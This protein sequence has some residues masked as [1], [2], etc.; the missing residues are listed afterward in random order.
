MVNEKSEVPKI[1]LERKREENVS[2]KS[3]K[4]LIKAAVIS[5]ISL[6]RVSLGNLP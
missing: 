6:S 1:Y 4:Y 5:K 2:E 3:D